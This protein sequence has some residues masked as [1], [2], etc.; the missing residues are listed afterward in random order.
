M[1]AESLTVAPRKPTARS[2]VTNGKDVLPDVD[3][4]SAVARRYR[5]ITG[6][7]VADQ[8]GAAQCS[9][10]R[11]QLIRRF[12]AAAV[13]AEQLE[14]KLAN[15]EEIDIAAHASLSSTLVRLAS[16]IGI[17]RVPRDVPTLADY[18]AARRSEGGP[19][20]LSDG[21]PNAETTSGE[22]PA[23]ELPNGSESYTDEVGELGG[24]GDGELG[25]GTD[26]AS[27]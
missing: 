9:E 12:A 4:R 10:S 1:H 16:R 22:K 25:D 26:E 3:G 27:L 20:D 14:A 23:G 11:Q 6:A 5:D 15:G 17:N 8:G 2:R 18:L 21:E 13:L 24:V 19:A 7:I